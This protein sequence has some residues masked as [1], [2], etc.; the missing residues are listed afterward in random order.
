MDVRTLRA[1]ARCRRSA[2]SS[3]DRLVRELAVGVSAAVVFVEYD[4]PP[5]ARY[6]VA[7]EQAY[8]TAQWITQQGRSEGLDGSRLAVTGDFVGGNMTA[9]LAILAKQGGDVVR[10]PPRRCARASRNSPGCPTPS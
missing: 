9:V 8:A 7:I 10:S 6:P 1:E 2:A 3:S 5:G 4:C